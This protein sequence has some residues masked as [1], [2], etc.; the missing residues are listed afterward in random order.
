[1][2]IRF[3]YFLLSWGWRPNMSVHFLRVIKYNSKA[4]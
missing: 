2:S 4:E 3:W 1:M